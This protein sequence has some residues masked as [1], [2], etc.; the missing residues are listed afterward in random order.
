MAKSPQTILDFVEHFHASQRA[1]QNLGTFS[2][3]TMLPESEA[4]FYDFARINSVDEIAY[5]EIH[6]A[7]TFCGD[8]LLRWYHANSSHNYHFFPTSG[9]SEAIFLSVRLLKHYWQ[10]KQQ[11]RQGKPNLIVSENSHV[12]FLSAARILDIEIKVIAIDNFNTWEPEALTGSINENTIGLIATLGSPTTLKM[13][14][15]AHLNKILYHYHLKTNHFIPLHVDAASGGFVVPFLANAPAWDFRLS[16]VKSINVS[17]HKFGLVYPSLGWL[18]VDDELYDHAL[19]CQNNYLGK[20]LKRLP[21]QFSHSA[22]HI[23]AQ[24]LNLIYLDFRGYTKIT[25]ELYDK[26]KYLVSVFEN[27]NEFRVL[28]PNHTAAIPGIVLTG[29][30]ERLERLSNQLLEKGWHMP[31]YQLKTSINNKDRLYASRMVIRYG[32]TDQ[33]IERLMNSF[34]QVIR[35]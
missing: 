22:S 14:S 25:N 10:A 35:S 7:M 31:V 15:V 9:S 28:T 12:A 8:T 24:A 26:T 21:V 34:S 6:Q 1:Q 29:A 32:M 3:T 4:A 19:T 23:I 27:S 13:D 16:H 20:E 11:N 5:P 17:S 2:T 30:Q 18:F 33:M